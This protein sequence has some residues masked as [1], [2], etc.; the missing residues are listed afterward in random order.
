MR[1]G[2]VRPAALRAIAAL[3]TRLA[4]AEPAV[5]HDAAAAITEPTAVD[6]LQADVSR[7]M[8][9]LLDRVDRFFGDERI[10]DDVGGSQ[11]RAGLG[12]RWDRAEGVSLVTRFRGRLDLPKTEK[13]LQLILDNLT[14][15]GDP[16][17]RS[18]LADTLDASQPDAG[19]RY[20]ARE[21]RRTR[22]SADV[23]ARLSETPQTF[24]RLR[25]RYR[26]PLGVWELRLTETA[27]WYTS[28]G[29]GAS[30]ELRWSRD[31]SNGWS[32]RSISRLEWE[33]S[34]DGVTPVQVFE[35]L[36][37]Q[38]ESG[39]GHR[40]SLAAEWPET[41]R[42]G[43]SSYS[44]SYGFRRT[45][46]RPWLLLEVA[47]GVAFREARDFEPDPRIELVF[48]AIFGAL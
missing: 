29:F 1:R 40:L 23:G 31:W 3:S 18:P 8:L 47:P 20:I 21:S 2:V 22:L 39:R 43:K 11:V 27:Y 16:L 7:H 46:G 25:F 38:P 15:T 9:A 30:T 32:F 48:E 6:R 10:E 5:P 4:T 13:R 17:E 12:L 34:R 45:L 14:E 44:A 37:A 19:L 41:P 36:R 26:L 28:D 35:W 33:E 24:G 42:G